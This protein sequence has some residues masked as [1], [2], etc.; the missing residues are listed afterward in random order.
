MEKREEAVMMVE[1]EQEE[2]ATVSVCIPPRNTLLLTRRR[3][4][5]ARMAALASRFRDSPAMQ[6]RGEEEED[7]GDENRD[8]HGEYNEE[9]EGE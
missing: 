2:E 1:K 5:P 6:V 9:G 8:H 7:N 4:D 3:S